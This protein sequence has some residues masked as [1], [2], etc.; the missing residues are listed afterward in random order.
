MD[1]D[2][3][4]LE[5]MLIMEEDKERRLA[6]KLVTLPRSEEARSVELTVS[7]RHL[8][9]S[10]LRDVIAGGTRRLPLSSY[11]TLALRHIR[12]KLDVKE[13]EKAN[14]I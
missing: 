11:D 8:L 13:R 3:N 14:A 12:D 4:F 9:D 5:E 2:R 7:E 1:I 6:E 10:V